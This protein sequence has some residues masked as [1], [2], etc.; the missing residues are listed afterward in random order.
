MVDTGSS[1]LTSGRP[2]T[3]LCHLP[4]WKP[5]GRPRLLVGGVGEHGPAGAV[6][7]PGEDIEDVDHPGRHRPELG[8]VGADPAVNGG[9]VGAGELSCQPPDPIRVDAGR[10][11]DLLRG[12]GLHGRRQL[13]DAGDMALQVTRI[14]QTLLEEDIGQGEE[15]QG[16]GAGA[17]EDVLVGGLGSPGPSRIHHDH[18]AAALPD[19]L[20]TT[21]PV[22][23][24]GQ[25]PV[26]LVR[27]GARA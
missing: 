25:A 23:G 12:E 6:Q 22:G 3:R 27:V 10:L 26:R 16:I 14:D 15:E 17:D 18:L 13:V 24:G 7:V 11:G 9:R 8:G 20:E 2:L 21:G 4:T 5:T 1:P 19:R